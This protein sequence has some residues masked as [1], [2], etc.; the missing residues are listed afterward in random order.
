MRE[1]WI[2]LHRKLFDNE[3]LAKSG[4]Y[5]RLEAWLWLLCSANFKEGKFALGTEVIIAKKGDVVT[6]QKKLCKKFKWG[7]TK[8]RNFLKLLE[9]DSMIELNTEAKLTRISICNYNTYQV[10]QTDNKSKANRRQIDDKSMTNTINKDN[11][12]NKVNKEKQLHTMIF[13]ELNLEKYGKPL[14]D[15]FFGHWSEKKIGGNK[16]RFEKQDAFSVPHRIATWAKNDYDSHYATHVNKKRNIKE[17]QERDKILQNADT[18]P[19][20]LKRYVK[21]ISMGI[22]KNVG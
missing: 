20:G 10:S 2:S 4:K 3:I 12:V 7:N 11:K 15:Q 13:T 18:D 16:M 6:S 21:G 14:L 17:Q 22:A 9:N 1:G 19:E 5:S 8:L